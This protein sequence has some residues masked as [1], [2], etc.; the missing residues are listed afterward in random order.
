MLERGRLR[1]LKGP[2]HGI[3]HW[4]LSRNG[5]SRNVMA[6]SM[7]FKLQAAAADVTGDSVTSCSCCCLI[8]SA[9]AAFLWAHSR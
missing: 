5:S 3:S 1:G 8:T 2:P 4:H 9:G 7:V 6:Y